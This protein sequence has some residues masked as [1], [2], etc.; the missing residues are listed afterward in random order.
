MLPFNPNQIL[1]TGAFEGEVGIL[2]DSRVFPHL[3]VMGIG[4]LEAAV[5][6]SDYLFRNKEIRRIVFFGSCGAYEWSGIPIKS[7]VSPNLVFT[8]ELTHALKLSKQIPESPDSYELIPDKNFRPVRC[9]A[10]TTITLTELKTPPEDS[11]VSLEVEN[12][13]LFGIAK[14]AAKFSISLTAYLAVTNLVGPNGSADWANHW[15]ELSHSLQ[16]QFLQK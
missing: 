12:L 7:V 13:E 11:W 2:R 3:R 1:V 5:N 9:N 4:N 6:L 14:V 10:P 15:K 16:N 8:K